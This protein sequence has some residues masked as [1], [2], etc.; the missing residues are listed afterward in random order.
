MADGELDQAEKIVKRILSAGDRALKILNDIAYSEI[1]EPELAD[2]PKQV[3]SGLI[4]TLRT[5]IG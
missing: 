3:L 2:I 4:R 5:R 1:P